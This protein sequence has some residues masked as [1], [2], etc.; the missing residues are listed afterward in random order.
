MT[1]FFL[2]LTL[3]R[4]SEA[5]TQAWWFARGSRWMT[6]NAISHNNAQELTKS[7]QEKFVLEDWFEK[8]IFYVIDKTQKWFSKGLKIVLLFYAR[9]RFF[10]Y[11][12]VEVNALKLVRWLLW[13]E[14][15][16]KIMIQVKYDNDLN[17]EHNIQILHIWFE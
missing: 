8:V 10:Y 15:W 5:H 12:C 11:I 1:L 16:A 14:S 17:Q 2:N 7:K 3:P 13:F 6:S 4:S 9:E